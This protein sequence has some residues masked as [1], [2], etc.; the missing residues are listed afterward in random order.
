MTATII[1]TLLFLAL[2]A[3]LP[4]AASAAHSEWSQADQAQ[5][6][7]LLAG[8]AADRIAGGIEIMM[9]PGWHTYWRNPGETGVPPA[10][11]FSGSDNVAAV[12]VFYPAPERLDDGTG[13]SLVYSDEVV[14]P[15]SVTPVEPERPVTLRLAASFGVCAEVCIPTRASSAVTLPAGAPA[16]P[17]ADATLARYQARVPKAPEPGRFDVEKVALADGALLIDVRTPDSSYLDLFAEPPEGWYI[18]QP[19]FVSRAG[20]VS[21]YRLAL[22]GRP[23][24]AAPEGQRFRFVAVA[25][26]EAVEKAIEIP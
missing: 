16:D 21:R 17:L 14:F 7:L 10:F 23:R 26:G 19:A 1:R 6:R 25:G 13:V 9:T 22:D 18:G 2:A 4:T 11:D 8:Q 3:A 5:V 12:E 20:G 15:L 24:G